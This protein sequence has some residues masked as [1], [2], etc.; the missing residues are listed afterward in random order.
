MNEVRLNCR[1][2]DLVVS[3]STWLS[4]GDLRALVKRA[5]ELQWT[6]SSLIAGRMREHPSRHD[7][8]IVSSLTI[9]GSPAA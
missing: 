8:R 7:V 9:E 5:D 3:D 6:D 2:D 1:P 4:L